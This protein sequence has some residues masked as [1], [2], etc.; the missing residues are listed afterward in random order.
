MKRVIAAIQNVLVLEAILN[1][2]NKRGMYVETSLSSE[3][4][5]IASLCKTIFAD[6]LVMDVTRFGE[7]AFDNR[8][9][10]INATKNQNPKI[11]ICLVYDN[12]MDDELLFKILSAKETGKIDMFF[13][14]SVPSDYIADVISTV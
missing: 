10:T 12:E 3:Y 6:V 13:Y 8:M 1:A 2:L 11:K 5:K 9:E 7:G 14:Q 4:Q